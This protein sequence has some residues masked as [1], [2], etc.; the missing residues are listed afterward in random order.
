M[1][2]KTATTV[3]TMRRRPTVKDVAPT[4]ASLPII[5][6]AQRVFASSSVVKRVMYDHNAEGTRQHK[7]RPITPPSTSA[8]ATQPHGTGMLRASAVCNQLTTRNIR[9]TVQS[10]FGTPSLLMRREILLDSDCAK[11]IGAKGPTLRIAAVRHP[12]MTSI[13]K[14]FQSDGPFFLAGGG[15]PVKGSSSVAVLCRLQQSQHE[16]HGLVPRTRLTHRLSHAWKCTNR[17]P[18]IPL[19]EATTK[20][21]RRKMTQL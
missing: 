13:A 4:R 7:K 3:D 16:E 14:S 1:T 8:G 2:S 5:S 6:C 20:H 11:K 10:E 21:S 19:T 9:Y 18:Q 17:P 12:T 15:L